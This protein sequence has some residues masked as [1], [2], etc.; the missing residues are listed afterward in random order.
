MKIAYLCDKE[1]YLKKMS[2]VR[3]HS[4]EAIEKMSTFLWS[5][6]NWENWDNNKTVD[7]NLEINNFSP[8]LIV[9]YKPLEIKGFAD[10]KFIKCLRYNEMYDDD[11]TRKE[12]NQSAADIVVCHHKNDWED[13]KDRKFHKPVNFINIPHCAERTV[14]KDYK[15][16]KIHDVLLVGAINVT[17]KFGQHY[18]LRQKMLEVLA[19]M[20]D[21][22][23]VGV[24]QHPGYILGDA[25]KNTYAIDFA[26]AINSAKIC[27]TCSG[28]PK[29]RFG[30]YVE[31]PACRTAI[32][33]DIPNEEQ[34]T[35][36]KFVIEINTED[37][38][39]TIIENLKKYLDNPKELEKVS[40]RGWMLMQKYTQEWYASVFIN[41]ISKIIQ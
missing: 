10:S 34:E 12:I 3:F 24:Y 2:R 28:M 38:N 37:D 1:H 41:N 29:S 8:D 33:A 14:F 39:K 6:P 7:E 15:L 9:G 26:K 18:P 17:T 13:W 32:A 31:I 20:S 23:K 21:D 4:M 16:P 25:H 22:Y 30:K 35:F 40:Y 27:V 11:W 19:E 36:K 5:G